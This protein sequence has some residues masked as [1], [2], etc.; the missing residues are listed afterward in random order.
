MKDNTHTIQRPKPQFAII[1]LLFPLISLLGIAL[2][3]ALS[4]LIEA[5]LLVAMFFY[6]MMLPCVFMTG[7]LGVASILKKER[8]RPI[9]IVDIL[10]FVYIFGRFTRL[11]WQNYLSF[12][13]F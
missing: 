11:G 9:A 2:G 10:I 8:W 7:I 3:L 5:Y 6:F 4:V 1:G 12:P 13:V